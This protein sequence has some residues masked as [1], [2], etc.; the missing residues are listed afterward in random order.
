MVE[1]QVTETI[2]CT[3]DE[4]LEFVMDIQRYAEVDEKIRPIDLVK[5][6]GDLTEFKFRPT[7]TGVLMPSPKWINQMRRTPGKR[8]DITN[9]PL[10]RNK[11]ANRMLTFTASFVVEPVDDATRVTRTVRMD[12]KP[13]ARWLA[14]RM[15]GDK[16]QTAAEDELR[17]AKEYLE[18]GIEEG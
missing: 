11:L 14:Q 8:I 15:I 18:S 12:F 16:L 1:A 2:R 9:A 5:R 10:P 7:L 13:Y 17:Q 6:D 3:P 4:L